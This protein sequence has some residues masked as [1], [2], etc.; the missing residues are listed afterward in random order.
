M[1]VRACVC[2]CVH[3]C[4][5]VCAF[6]TILYKYSVLQMLSS[7]LWLSFSN[8]MKVWDWAESNNIPS[9]ASKAKG[10]ALNHFLVLRHTE[11]F[12]QMPIERLTMMLGHE[13]LRV[14]T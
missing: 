6:S 4:V 8:C 1:Y 13:L 3:V 14:G 9:L 5:Y 7:Q 11:E 2:V 12:L 10:V